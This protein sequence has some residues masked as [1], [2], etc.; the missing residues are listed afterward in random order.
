MNP[1]P[2]RKQPCFVGFFN[3]LVSMY[4]WVV[5]VFVPRRIEKQVMSVLIQNYYSSIVQWTMAI[6]DV[7]Q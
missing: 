5:V 7:T 4:M 2:E 6:D 3:L 1:V